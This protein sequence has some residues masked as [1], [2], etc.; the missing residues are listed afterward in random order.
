ME[1]VGSET[2]AYA[3]ADTMAV[4]I[5]CCIWC[6]YLFMNCFRTQGEMEPEGQELSCVMPLVAFYI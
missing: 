3:I 6:F 4:S 5:T 2:E 1:T